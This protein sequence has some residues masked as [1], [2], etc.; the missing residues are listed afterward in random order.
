VGKSQGTNKLGSTKGVGWDTQNVVMEGHRD[1]ISREGRDGLG[2]CLG[3]KGGGIWKG[4]A[5]LH[6]VHED[7]VSGGKDDELRICLS[8]AKWAMQRRRARFII[9]LCIIVLGHLCEGK[10][11]SDSVLE[12][13]RF[14]CTWSTMEGRKRICG[15]AARK[16]DSTQSGRH[17]VF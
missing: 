14:L 12:V 4:E 5:N 8:D 15:G 16:H 6:T 3:R 2:D 7:S 1:Y 10:L 17:G 13:A 11:Q 9:L